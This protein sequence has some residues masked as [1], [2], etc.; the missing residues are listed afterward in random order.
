LLDEMA[1]SW[2]SWGAAC[3]HRQPLGVNQDHDL[4]AFARP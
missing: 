2:I 3:G 1:F 4:D